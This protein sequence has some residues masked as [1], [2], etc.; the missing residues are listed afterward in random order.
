MNPPFLFNHI[1]I[2]R[3]SYRRKLFLN[4]L[5]LFVLLSAVLLVFQWQRERLIRRQMLGQQL[6]ATAYM[7]SL[8]HISEPTRLL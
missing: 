5:V 6:G 2:M 3:G 1:A 7:L 8:I 4:Y